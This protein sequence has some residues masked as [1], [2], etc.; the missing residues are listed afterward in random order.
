MPSDRSKAH[1]ILSHMESPGSPYKIIP[2]SPELFLS[3]ILMHRNRPDKEWSLTDCISFHLM[4]ERGIQRALT[5]D[6]HFAQA[7]FQPLMRTHPQ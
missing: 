1:L 5:Y 2:T 6:L 4:Q 7:G 3:G